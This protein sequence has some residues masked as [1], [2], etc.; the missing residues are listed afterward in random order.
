[1]SDRVKE[2]SAYFGDNCHLPAGA[3]CDLFDEIQQRDVRIGK[4]LTVLYSAQAFMRCPT[5]NHTEL[6]NLAE[7]LQEAIDI[8]SDYDPFGDLQKSGGFPEAQALGGDD[9]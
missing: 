9:E 2:W 6:S 7:T 8:A 1:M 5:E 4:L 3:I